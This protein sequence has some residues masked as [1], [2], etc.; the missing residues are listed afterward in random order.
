MNLSTDKY[1]GKGKH[2]VDRKLFHKNKQNADGLQYYCMKC[3]DEIVKER[4]RKL[5]EG[6]I[7]AF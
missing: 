1:C 7:K 3:T 6:T 5:K 2:W 4:H